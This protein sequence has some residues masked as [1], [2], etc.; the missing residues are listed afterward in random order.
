MAVLRTILPARVCLVVHTAIVWV[1]SITAITAFST[2]A[3]AQYNFRNNGIQS[4]RPKWERGG[5]GSDYSWGTNRNRGHHSNGGYSG[6]YTPLPIF[7]PGA[8]APGVYYPGYGAG[9][10]MGYGLGY[11]DFGYGNGS[12]GSPAYFGNSTARFNNW[13]SSRATFSAGSF[14]ANRHGRI[15]SGVTRGTRGSV[16]YSAL[17]GGWYTPYFGVSDTFY[18][19]WYVPTKTVVFNGR[20]TIVRASGPVYVLPMDSLYGYIGPMPSYGFASPVWPG[21]GFVPSVVGINMLMVSPVDPIFP[22]STAAYTIVPPPIRNLP[23]PQVELLPQVEDM[24]DEDLQIPRNAGAVP[25]INEFSATAVAQKRTSL[26]DKIQSLRYQASGD[27]AFRKG[28]YASADVFYHAAIDAAPARRAPWLRLTIAQVAQQQFAEAVSSLKA[29]LML[30]EETTRV[31]ITSDELYGTDANERSRKHAGDLW[32]WL[33]EEPLSTD[34]LLLS[35]FFQKHR[36]FDGTGDELLELASHNGP[37]AAYVTAV[38][39]ITRNDGQESVAGSG[40]PPAESRFDA[41]PP[42]PQVPLQIPQP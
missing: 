30:P 32:T 8:M 10:G 16:H 9:Y 21:V 40:S 33:A 36:R 14:S 6:G 35:G 38:R 29:G 24:A 31:W 11:G 18:G 4:D 1:I 7:V 39:Q 20:T 41:V 17:C 23:D 12:W 27:E 28:E 42:V 25:I 2:T 5:I 15:I 34:R 13:P 19:S 3:V 26:A 37:E 22:P